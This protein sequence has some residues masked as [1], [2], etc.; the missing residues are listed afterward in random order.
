MTTGGRSPP[1]AA[2]SPQHLG[3]P[4][5]IAKRLIQE[6]KAAAAELAYHHQPPRRKSHQKRASLGNLD[7]LD[8][9]RSGQQHLL[10]G[11]GGGMQ[12]HRQSQGNLEQILSGAA[13]IIQ[14]Q[15]PTHQPLPQ[16]QRRS[17]KPFIIQ[18]HKKLTKA[19]VNFPPSPT[20]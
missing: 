5:S 20:L 17:S 14:Q 7:E 19:G 4:P 10:L 13:S 6:T 18:Q 2:I 12:P 1:S 9:R 16:Q 11:T 8:P 15:Y 3:G